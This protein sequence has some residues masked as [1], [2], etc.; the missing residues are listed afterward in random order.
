LVTKTLNIEVASVNDAPVATLTS[1][2]TNEDNSIVIDVLASASDIDGDVLAINSISSPANGSAE[3]I[4]GKI[5]YAPNQNFFGQ[6]SFNYT[7]SDQNGGLVTKTAKITINP[8]NDAPIS[9]N[10]DSKVS[11]NSSLTIDVLANSSDVDGDIL[12]ISSVSSPENGVAEIVDGKI[13]FTP[14]S[15]FNGLT[16]FNYTISD[17][18]GGLVTKTINI[19]VEAVNKAPITISDY[20]ETLED[21]SIK[22]LFSEI[23]ANDSDAE[24]GLEIQ[25]LSFEN[26]IF[27]NP[28][29]G[30]LVINFDGF[31]YIPNNNYYGNDSFSYQIKDS[32]GALSNPSKVILN[33]ASVNDA[34]TIKSIISSVSTNEDAEN[35]VV[36]SQIITSAFIDIEGDILTYQATL[37][38]G[39]PLPSWLAINGSTGEITSSN[40]S[41]GD[42]G[43]YEIKITATDF[44][45]ANVSQNFNIEVAN[46]NDV[47]TAFAVNSSALEDS[48][49]ITASFN[50]SDVDLGDAVSYKILSNPELGEVVNNNDGTFTFNLGENFNNLKGGQVKNI[51]FNYAAIDKSGAQSNISSVTIQITGTNDAPVATLTSVATNEDNV[52]TIDVLASASD[53]DGDILT[54]NSISSPANGSAQIVD[55]KIIYAPNQ[56]FFGNDSLNY[57]ITDNK[58]GVVTKTLNIEVASVND[59]PTIISIVETKEAK[60]GQEFSYEVPSNLFSDVDG[61][62]LT[63][64]A[65]L[66]DGS[67]LPNWLSFDGVKFSG[68]PNIN[69]Q[70]LSIKLTAADN[71]GAS[72]SQDFEIKISNQN[73]APQAVDDLVNLRE[74]SSLYIGFYSILQNDINVKDIY[75][76]KKDNIVFDEPVNGSITF[77]GSYGLR[78]R[79]NSNYNGAETVGYQIKDSQGN[80]SNKAFI[81]FNVEAVNDTPIVVK[82]MN[83]QTFY[84]TKEVKISAKNVFSDIDG[85]ILTLNATLYD[86][87]P[88]PSWLNFNSQTQEFYGVAPKNYENLRIKLS[89]KDNAGASNYTNF[90]LTIDNK[91]FIGSDQNDIINASY[92]R[93]MIEG[94][95]G[96]D[97]ITGHYYDEQLFGGEGNDIIKSNYGRDILTGDAGDDIF[98]IGNSAYLT[99][100]TDFDVNN[101]NEKIDLNEFNIKNYYKI[102]KISDLQMT[103]IGDDVSIKLPSNKSLIVKNVKV[104]QLTKDKFILDNA[105]IANNDYVSSISE[106]AQLKFDIYTILRNDKLIDDVKTLTKE[107]IIFKKPQ[108]GSI[109][110]IDDQV[111]YTPNKDFN[112]TET[113]FY[114]I[115]D[116]EGNLS[117]FAK[118]DVYIRSVNDAPTLNSEIED[119]KIIGGSNLVFH[120]PKNI[121]SDVDGDNLYYSATLEDGSRLPSWLRFDSSNRVFYGSAPKEQSNLNIKIIAKDW[122]GESISDIFKL[123][124]ILDDNQKAGLNIK[125]GFRNDNLQGGAYDDNISDSFGNDHVYGFEGNDNISNSFGNDY[126][127]GGAGDDIIGDSFGNDIIYGGEGN[128]IIKDSFGDDEIYGGAGNDI[129]NDSF[130]DDEIYGGAGDDI[131]G[132][133]F[134]NDI[135][136]GGSGH[137]I[138][139]AGS[140]NDKII[141]GLGADS[142]RGGSGS[143]TF[144]F[145][146]LADS[147]LNESD[148][149]LDFYQR[150]K[151]KIDVSALNFN[152]ISKAGEGG[153]LQYYFENNQTIVK[154]ENSDFAFKLNSKVNLVADDFIF[155]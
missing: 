136:Y 34:P 52:L 18:N 71:S 35:I 22:I 118:F 92:D 64:S 142:L 15:N 140:G 45:G 94:G 75:Q 21:R 139:S 65:N 90:Y 81:T 124:F 122:R 121:F 86:G 120:L 111:I 93:R 129:I 69:G 134:G 130:G 9:V 83:S 66:V 103:Q 132:D 17:G 154:E 50:A 87:S 44:F 47:P 56:N 112:G 8:E 76:F 143:D 1:A 106:D 100:I 31:T 85:D 48:V 116:S 77:V 128:D 12:T 4:D 91:I 68:T 5:I 29:N 39:Q 141:G 10:I 78:Y 24:D 149:I 49:Q 11:E 99:T 109:E 26:I 133:S 98:V 79:P 42:V 104:E 20:F 33:I 101:P 62:N 37:S 150:D 60:V 57:T 28:E 25:N 14:N 105:P 41:N 53:I 59:A 131:I 82:S 19:D 74:D 155:G 16:N 144:I 61:D 67:P 30:I 6:D 46:V 70:N 95:K 97:K 2:A 88:L 63:I 146:N 107:N 27:D 80:L 54:I 117:N 113:V 127:D 137:D 148:V 51:S 145:E 115:K 102:K 43:N 89:A 36:N 13:I 23:L 123:E 110:I 7:I 38:N 114:Q 72:V 125:G 108:N 152:S 138:I 153:D 147:N 119:K 126:I 32:D 55:G 84:S 151:D 96:D 73:N 40:P 58:G 3:I 135:I